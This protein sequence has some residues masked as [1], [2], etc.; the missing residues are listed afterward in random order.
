MSSHGWIF[1]GLGVVI[2]LCV[3]AAIHGEAA[4]RTYAKQ[5]R[6]AEVSRAW[7]GGYM[8][9]VSTGNGG[10]MSYWVDQGDAVTYKCDNGYVTR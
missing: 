9:T 2:S 1:C 3:A 7:R 8:Q 5:H 10:T 6:C 4:W